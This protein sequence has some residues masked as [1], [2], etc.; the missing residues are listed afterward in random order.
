MV[1]SSL[2]IFQFAFIMASPAFT[3]SSTYP[4][5]SFPLTRA[6]VQRD[7]EA[8]VAGWICSPHRVNRLFSQGLSTLWLHQGSQMKTALDYAASLIGGT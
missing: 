3:I 5:R 1:S 7:Y 6:V 8:A 4:W 2:E